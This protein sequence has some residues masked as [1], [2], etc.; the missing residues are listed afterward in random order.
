MSQPKSLRILDAVAAR[1]EAI[2]ESA[3]YYT[4]I[5]DDVRLDQ[6]DPID[7]ELPV[8]LVYFG[9]RTLSQS[10]GRVEQDELP[11]GGTAT[12][13]IPLTVV[14]FQEVGRG[15]SFEVLGHQ[16]VA[17]IQAAVEGFDETLSGLVLKSGGGLAW[18]SDQTFMPEFGSNVVGAAVTY[19]VPHIRKSG[20]PER[21]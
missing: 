10:R 8:A 7:H 9:E 14:G 13:T 6:R 18:Q 5:G 12:C 17:D 1:V 20:D 15:Q 16:M 4:N 21:A 11:R 2:R 19:L 3:G